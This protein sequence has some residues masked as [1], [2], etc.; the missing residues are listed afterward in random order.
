MLTKEQK[1]EA[2][3]ELS[4]LNGLPPY[5]D[6]G[7]HCRDDGYFAASLKRKYNMDLDDLADHC[8]FNVKAQLY[9]RLKAAVVEAIGLEG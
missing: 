3:T 5:D 8:G 2:F 7:N 1:K 9:K 4:M 6:G